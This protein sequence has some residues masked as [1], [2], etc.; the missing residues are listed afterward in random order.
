MCAYTITRGMF[1][2]DTKVLIFMKFVKFTFLRRAKCAIFYVTTCNEL[3][4]YHFAFRIN[5]VTHHGDIT[6][7]YFSFLA[8]EDTNE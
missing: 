4:R 3:S 1:I 7:F 6:K 8:R 2:I 5:N